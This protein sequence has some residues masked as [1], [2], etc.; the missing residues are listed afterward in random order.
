MGAALGAAT[1]GYSV[2][3]AAV[4]AA[5]GAVCAGALAKLSKL[6]GVIRANKRAGDAF[7]AVLGIASRGKKAI[8]SMSGTAARRFPDELTEAVVREA[9]SG[10]HVKL[11][12]QVQDFIDYAKDQ[13]RQFILEIREAAKVDQKLLDL[14]SAGEITIRRTP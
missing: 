9:K 13:G 8:P 12:N 10:S 6:G 1:G 4:D 14:E 7:E 11:T 5:S 3:A 2:G